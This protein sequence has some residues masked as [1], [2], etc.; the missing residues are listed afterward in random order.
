MLSAMFGMENQNAAMALISSSE[1]L[2]ELIANITGTNT[3]YE[4]GCSYTA[5]IL[6]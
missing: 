5:K 6:I 4:Q 2:A 3:A 1:E